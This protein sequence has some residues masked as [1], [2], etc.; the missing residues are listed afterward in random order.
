MLS[1]AAAAVLPHLRFLSWPQQM[2]LSALASGAAVLA[3]PLFVAA[4]AAAAGDV[5][6]RSASPCDGT[7]TVVPL[8]HST[9]LML[10]EATASNA[11]PVQGAQLHDFG[12]AYP[13]LQ[14]QFLREQ[15]HLC[16]GAARS[17]RELL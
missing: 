5:S 17:V 10:T 9:V 4:A 15:D 1:P 3:G 13:L 12:Q 16:S 2:E 14:L 7:G 6:N 8:M 11:S